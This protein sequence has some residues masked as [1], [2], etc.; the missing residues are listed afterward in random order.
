M[1][2]LDETF[3]MLLG[4]LKQPE[5]LNPAKSD[6]FFYFVHEPAETLAIKQ[7]LAVWSSALTNR[8]GWTVEQVS[9]SKLLWE[10]VDASGR[11]DEWL[12]LEPDSDPEAMNEAI[13]NVLRTDNALVESLA[14]H[15]SN[16]RARTLVFV[17]DA[18]AL[19]PYFRARSLES[20]L[21]DRVKVPT[22]IFYPG[23]RSG[24]YGLHFLGFYE[25]DGNYRATLLGGLE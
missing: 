18:A 9:L 1:P 10:I 14:R 3:E 24:Q 19:H 8:Q 21:H 16:E 11:W 17:T 13:S 6:P 22:V 4:H 5:S 7:K 12:A 20:G 2:S 15:I 25:F 23:R